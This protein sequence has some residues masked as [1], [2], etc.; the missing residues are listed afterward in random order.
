MIGHDVKT[1]P[2][3][4]WGRI[5]NGELLARA[6]GAFDILVTIDQSL[7]FQQNI[8]RFELRLIVI[9]SKT[10]RLADIAPLVP[11][12]LAAGRPLRAAEGHARSRMTF[13]Y[14]AENPAHFRMRTS[15]KRRNMRAA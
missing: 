10:N 5:K 3:A 14:N 11:G 15:R 12:I 1:V 6:A 7:T 8:A 13:V 9:H 2:Q 4:G